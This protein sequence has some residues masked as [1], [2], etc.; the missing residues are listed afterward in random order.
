LCLLGFDCH[1]TPGQ[2]PSKLIILNSVLQFAAVVK[3]ENRGEDRQ[4][5]AEERKQV[6]QHA[7]IL[8]NEVR[9]ASARLVATSIEAPSILSKMV[10]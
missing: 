6:R 4:S 2:N 8:H 7:W 5:P 1:F 9:R 10:G 3:E